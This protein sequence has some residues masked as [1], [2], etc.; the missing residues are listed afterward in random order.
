[1]DR[2]LALIAQRGRPTRRG[3]IALWVAEVAEWPV[4]GSKPVGATRHQH[5]RQRRVPLVAGIVG[6]EPADDDSTGPTRRGIIGDAEMQC[7]QARARRGQ[8]FD[9][10]HA[11]RGLHEGLDA[12]AM[13]DA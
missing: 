5:P 1:M 10:G 8:R 2:P 4:D 11:E 9:V 6:V 12:D 3:E 7:L 13:A